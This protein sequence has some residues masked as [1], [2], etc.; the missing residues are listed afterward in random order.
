MM[1]G[2]LPV[3]RLFATR[4]AVWRSQLPDSRRCAA[5]TPKLTGADEGGVR[6]EHRVRCVISNN[7]AAA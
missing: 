6:V 2:V 5:R 1:Q 4:A 7:P 3:E